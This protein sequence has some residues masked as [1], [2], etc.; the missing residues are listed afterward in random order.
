MPR[1]IVA[2]HAIHNVDSKK[3]RG[4]DYSLVIVGVLDGATVYK[5]AEDPINCSLIKI[6][7]G[8]SDQLGREL[9][10]WFVAPHGL[11]EVGHHRV[12]ALLIQRDVRCRGVDFEQVAEEHRP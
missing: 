3:L 6:V 8:R 11:P 2:K 12:T 10:V 7:A 4:C 5:S 9:I 1:S